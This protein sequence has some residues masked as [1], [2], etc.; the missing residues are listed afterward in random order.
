MDEIVSAVL[1][2]AR[3]LRDREVNLQ[4][5]RLDTID[6]SFQRKVTELRQQEVELKA[7]CVWGWG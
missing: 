6:Q 7:R 2:R 4:A 3:A 5:A 1:A